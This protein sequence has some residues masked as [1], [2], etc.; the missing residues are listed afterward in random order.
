MNKD[1]KFDGNEEENGIHDDIFDSPVINITPK[2]DSPELMSDAD[3][4][5]GS[6]VSE[7]KYV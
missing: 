7:R 6:T 2:E 3:L 5:A 4:N 1:Y